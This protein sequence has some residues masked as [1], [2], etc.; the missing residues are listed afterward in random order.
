MQMFG[1][2]AVFAKLKC[3]DTDDCS[4]YLTIRTE[5]N[6]SEIS[7][8]NLLFLIN[9]TR[10][11]ALKCFNTF[12]KTSPTVSKMKCPNLTLACNPSVLYICTI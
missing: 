7:F 1:A 2:M 3:L 9:M 4:L 8:Q 6:R 11:L 12:S 10:V 5:M